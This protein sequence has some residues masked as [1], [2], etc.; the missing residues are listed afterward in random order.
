M[1]ENTFQK[2]QTYPIIRSYKFKIHSSKIKLKY[3]FKLKNKNII[4]SNTSKIF[5]V[6]TAS[7]ATKQ[8]EKN[9]Y[10]RTNKG[11]PVLPPH[12]PPS[13]IIFPLFLFLD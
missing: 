1:M 9:L 7:V 2:Y 12:S 4:N 10:Y 8:P 11:I 6:S 13:F 5:S 3:L